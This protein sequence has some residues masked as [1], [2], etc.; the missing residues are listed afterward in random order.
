MAAELAVDMAFSSARLNLN[1]TVI[2]D[3]G[4]S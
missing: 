3:Q 2:K 4:C 1:N